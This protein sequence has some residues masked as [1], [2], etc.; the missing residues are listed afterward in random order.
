[1]S[2]T[3]NLM[4]NVGSRLLPIFILAFALF[5]SAKP[6]S[7]CKKTNSAGNDYSLCEFP[8]DV[9]SGVTIKTY[10]Q[11]PK[12]QPYGSF[13]RLQKE[14][15][16]E[17]TEILFACNGGPSHPDL[18]PIGLYTENSKE[19]VPIT[20]P[21]DKGLGNLFIRPNGVFFVNNG[22]SEILTTED[23]IEKKISPAYALQSGPML[24]INEKISERL[25]PK[26]TSLKTR[27]GVCTT[28]DKVIFIVSEQALNFY[29][30]ATYLKSIGCQNA[31]TLDVTV[32]SFLA[33]S[34]NRADVWIPIGAM[35]AVTQKK[36]R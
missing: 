6:T 21:E 4:N 16:L 18:S 23:Y 15:A 26:G 30:F 10:W 20:K 7:A 22:H 12:G 25:D 33:P 34:L 3:E 31:L 32:S 28:N 5:A 11:N 13:I 8:N 36:K 9:N 19:F 29:T 1:M 24:L 14:L 2:P 35:I 17:K 27:N